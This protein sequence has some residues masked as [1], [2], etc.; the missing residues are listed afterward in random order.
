MEQQMNCWEK[1]L[2]SIIKCLLDIEQHLD[3][4]QKAKEKVKKYEEETKRKKMA[5]R[6]IEKAKELIEACNVYL[7]LTNRDKSN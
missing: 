7:T 1:H 4:G 3:K 2:D 5:K 6:L